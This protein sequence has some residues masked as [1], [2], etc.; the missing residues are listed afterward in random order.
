MSSKTLMTVEQFEQL[1]AEE[2]LKYELS[3]GE[4]VEVSSGTPK[5]AL[6]R[7][8]ILFLLKQQFRKQTRGH[9]LAEV[10]FRVNPETVRRPDVSVLTKQQWESIDQNR[11]IVPF[12]PAMAIEVASPSDTFETLFGKALEYLSAG[13]EEVWVVLT[14]PVREVHVFRKNG[15][16]LL[17]R[18]K[19]QLDSAAVNGLSV[20]VSEFFL[21]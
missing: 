7:D 19:E 14:D 9:A 4:L 3:Q 15:E 6:V 17:A 10:E 16:R 8:N 21:E 13:T 1:P 20:D 18:D 11:S 5:H 2:A 12:A